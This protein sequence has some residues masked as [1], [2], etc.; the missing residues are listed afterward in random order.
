MT[1][2]LRYDVTG[3][4]GAPF[5][6]MSAGLGGAGAYWQPQ[7]PALSAG[8][9]VITYD[10]RGTG[11]NRQSVADGVTI[12]DMA[13]DVVAIINDVGAPCHFVGHA[14]GGLIGLELARNHPGKLRSL[15]LVNAWARLDPHTAR[16]FDV[17][18]E[19]L[20]ASGP[21][22]YISGER[23]CQSVAR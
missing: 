2:M 18:T 12:G 10:Q 5:V 4:A 3:P 13:D 19:I 17:R 15:V 1:D 7:I 11:R 6:V 20:N 8:Y 21:A 23:R 22:A 14:L 9:L 16:C